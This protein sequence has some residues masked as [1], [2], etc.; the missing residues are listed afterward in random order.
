MAVVAASLVATTAGALN[1]PNTS[2]V[3]PT[4]AQLETSIAASVLIKATPTLSTTV[5]NLL[6]ITSADASMSPV[7]L[8]CYPKSNND[9]VTL[10]TD[11]LTRCAYGNPTATR[12]ILLTG[13]SNAALIQ[14]A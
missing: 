14:T 8:A 3:R 12:V 11:A 7:R 13:D 10:P 2:L 6:S 5:P 1:V 4:L 9:N